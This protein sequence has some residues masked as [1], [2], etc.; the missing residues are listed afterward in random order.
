[1]N[2]TLTENPVLAVANEDYD[3]YLVRVDERAVFALDVPSGL[4]GLG[5][6]LGDSPLATTPRVFAPYFIAMNTMNYM[7]WNVAQDGSFT[8][9]SLNGK[10]G[11]LAM[12]DAFHAAWLACGGDK[13]PEKATMALAARVQA[14]GV[15][16]LFGDIPS[17]DTRRELLLEVLD[18]AKLM[19]AGNYL[20]DRV[21]NTG[22][23]G[24]GDAQLLAYLFPRSYGDSYLKKAQLTLMFIAGEWNA[25]K[26]VLPCVLD[27]TA[28]A[29]YQLPKVLRTLGLLEYSGEAAK[30][31]DAGVLVPENG[32]VERAIR[33][34]TVLA[35][36]QLAEHFKCTIA[37]VDFWLWLNRN[38][39][40]DAKFH[41]TITT[42]Y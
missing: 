40:R 15:G 7:F 39:D 22:S 19:A 32:V 6:T 11:A 5:S 28:A 8:R 34:A 24:W 29:D 4:Q 21:L 27:V 1:M 42:A 20:A 17:A 16:F 26:P 9:Y 10:V 36:E 23:L 3:P 2:N 18:P 12:Q 25:Q 31:V 33:A 38:K 13:H 41:L 14:E 37:E 35:C 30:A